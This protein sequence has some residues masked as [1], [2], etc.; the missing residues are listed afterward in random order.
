MCHRQRAAVNKSSGAK[1]GILLSC[2]H[3]GA[4][5]PCWLPPCA[6]R[7]HER[8]ASCSLPPLRLLHCPMARP[9]AL[10]LQV[11][12]D[13]WSNLLPLPHTQLGAICKGAAAVLLWHAHGQRDDGAWGGDGF[14]PPVAGV[15]AAA[16]VAGGYAV[17]EGRCR[18]AT[19]PQRLGQP[20]SQPPHCLE[21]QCVLLTRLC[22]VMM[23]K[24][25]LSEV[26]HAAQA[27]CQTGDGRVREE[28][29]IY[30]LQ[31]L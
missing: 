9:C 6:M 5:L 15:V 26:Q 25:H 29:V 14:V 8:A 21:K 1:L 3:V 4:Y 24:H 27:V 19:A 23:S 31:P 20:H 16:A 30:Q 28:Q 17:S 12:D 10:V 18:L 2:T 22:L 11:H 7:V 13:P